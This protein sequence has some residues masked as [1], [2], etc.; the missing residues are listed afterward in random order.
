[1][2]DFDIQLEWKNGVHFVASDQ[3]KNQISVDGSAEIGGNNQGTRPMMMVLMGLASCASMDIVTI[4]KKSRQ[5]FEQFNVK[6]FAKRSNDIPKVFTEIHLLFTVKGEVESKRLDAAV[7]LSVEK[8]CSVAT[9]LN[10]T[11]KITYSTTI[12]E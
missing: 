7:S 10:K 8:Y 4:L 11:A 3:E 12:I 5:P 9:M 2:D 1:M 6:V